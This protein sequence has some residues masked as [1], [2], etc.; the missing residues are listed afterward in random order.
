M[1]HTDRI[2]IQNVRTLNC[3]LEDCFQAYISTFDF[4]LLILTVVGR[5]TL[6]YLQL[7][8]WSKPLASAFD[9]YYIYC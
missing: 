9:S 2:F 5:A 4:I 8:N 1:V 3:S 6:P 7:W